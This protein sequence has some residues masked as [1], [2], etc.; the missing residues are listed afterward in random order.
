MKEAAGVPATLKIPFQPFY[1]TPLPIGAGCEIISKDDETYTVK[2]P[3]V[4]GFSGS[5]RIKKTYVKEN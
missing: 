2:F 5:Y 4:V 3:G 1:N